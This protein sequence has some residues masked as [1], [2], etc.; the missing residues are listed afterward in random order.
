MAIWTQILEG[1]FI[2]FGAQLTRV[3]PALAWHLAATAFCFG[4]VEGFG[5]RTL[6]VFKV[7][8]AEALAGIEASP[9]IVRQDKAGGT[10]ALEA[11]WCV[12]A[13]TKEA[14]VGVLVTFIYINAIFAFHFISGGTDAPE[15][16]LQILTG[17]RGAGARECDT[18]ISIDTV[19]AI[20]SKFVALV[21][22]TLEGADF[23]EAPPVSAH[24][25]K[26]RAALVYV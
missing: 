13:G 16:S 14:N 18:L 20:R 23:I 10:D 5:Y 12:G 19:L 2:V 8:E 21:A 9:S 1:N 4:G 17:P 24:L 11:P 26:E 15:G 3:P 6:S 7:G 22:Q 25:A